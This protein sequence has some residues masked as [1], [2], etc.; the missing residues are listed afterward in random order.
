MKN[1]MGG[2]AVVLG[3]MQAI[4]G[5]QPDCVVHGIIPAAENMPD[6]NSIRPGDVIRSK[7]G[8]TVEVM[9]TDAEGRLVLADA[10]AYALEQK[11][12]DIMDFATLTGVCLVAL[13]PSTAGAYASSE[14]MAQDIKDAW[15]KTGE[16][17]WPMPLD[18]DLREQFKS[19]IADIK[20][21]GEDGVD[22]LLLHYSS[23][24]LSAAVSLAGLISI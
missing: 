13:G 4:A 3:A 17:F 9:N 22:R 6:G 7:S 16:K 2:A 1:D 24:R 15:I 23:K 19:D 8:L 18:S 11:P 21:L 5:L 20:N 14:T 12:T 10:I